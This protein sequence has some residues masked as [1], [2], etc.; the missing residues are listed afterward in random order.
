MARLD[1]TDENS[2]RTS[3]DPETAAMELPQRNALTEQS[4][5]HPGAE[6]ANEAHIMSR[7]TEQESHKTM[8]LV[9]IF[10][11]EARRYKAGQRNR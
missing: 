3:T 9:S 11:Y 6:H 4:K 10:V 5:D 7:R 1:T 2:P 8:P